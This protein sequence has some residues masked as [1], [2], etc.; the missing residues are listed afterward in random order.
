MSWRFGMAT[1]CDIGIPVD[2]ALGLFA[3]AGVT[4]AEISTPPR[5]F[6][7]WQPGQVRDLGRHLTHLGV[8]PISI[9]APFGKSFDLSDPDPSRR[10]EAI[11]SILISA[12]AIRDF[13]GFRVVAHTTDVPRDGQDVGQRLHQCVASLETA[14]RACHHMGV[15][16]IVETPLPHLIGGHPDEFAWILQHLDSRV[17][18]CIDTG[19]VSLGQHW[20]AMV[21]IAGHRLI[22]VHANDNRGQFDDHLPPGDGAI[23][24]LPVR[25]SLKRADFDG[26]IMLEISHPAPQSPEFL[27]G[28][29]CRARDL[30]ME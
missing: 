28:A 8:E 9:H 20:D 29:L 17:G 12:S 22:H 25:E 7:P 5:H 14:S 6:D 23:D 1:G 26:W 11:G 16:L 27:R 4:A 15:P 13:G 3:K 21:R 2:L 30:L 18:V 10:A 24:W 19:H